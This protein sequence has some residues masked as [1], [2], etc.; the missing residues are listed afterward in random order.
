MSTR[1]GETGFPRQ[2]PR[3]LRGSERLRRMVRETE[4]T[5][6]GL[7]YPMFVAPG[8][9]LKR[10]IPSMPGNFHWSVDRLPAEVEE[11]A[12]LGIPAVLLFGLPES[13]DPVGSGAYADTGIV[14]AAVRA[15]KAAVPDLLVITD[16]CLC[17][18]TSHGHCGV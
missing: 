13:K 14:Q 9:G 11:I 10:E 1:P 16:V 2:R 4:V 15:I 17:E 5:T 3:R 8:T 7:V 6:D 12:G 18:Y